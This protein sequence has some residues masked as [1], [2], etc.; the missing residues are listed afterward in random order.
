[1]GYRMIQ[2][3]LSDPPSISA[4]EEEKIDLEQRNAADGL[5]KNDFSA[6]YDQLILDDDIEELLQ[7]LY[8]SLGVDELLVVHE[9]KSAIFSKALEMVKRGK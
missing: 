2:K 5:I 4:A 3:N 6:V 7:C 8:R 9:L 1:M